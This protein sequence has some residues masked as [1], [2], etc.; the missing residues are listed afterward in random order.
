[1]KDKC[2]GQPWFTEKIAGQRRCFHD[3][4]VEW[5]KCIDPGKKETKKG[6]VSQSEEG[7]C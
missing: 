5:L 7:I 1:M 6:G 2:K 3:A 4:E